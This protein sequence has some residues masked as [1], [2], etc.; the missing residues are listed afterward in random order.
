MPAPKVVLDC[1]VLVQ[2]A[3]RH[4]GT[5]RACFDAARKSEIEL[6]AS[7]QT[8]AEL[9]DVLQRPELRSKLSE[10][11][12][13]RADRFVQE[14][15]RHCTLI[16]TVPAVYHHPFDEKDAPYINLAIAAEVEYLVT[17]DKRHLLTL[18]D[19][20]KPHGLDFVRRFP[21]LRIIAP[22]QFLQILSL[23]TLKPD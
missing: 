20:S 16:E 1:M 23:R 10:L 8:I 14:L 13:E 15:L 6:C 12:D 18:M 4:R 22:E 5:S 11:T 3:A 9:R 21:R 2:A 19:A 17:R 7:P